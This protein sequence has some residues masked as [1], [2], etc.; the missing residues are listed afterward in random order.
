MLYKQIL[1]KL[2]DA[3]P[4]PTSDSI[5]DAYLIQTISKALEQVDA[6]KTEFN[7]EVPILGK[8]NSA[9]LDYRAALKKRLPENISSVEA[10]TQELVGYLDGMTIWGHPRCQKNVVTQPSIASLIGMILV[11]LYNP[12]LVLEDASQKVALAEVEAMAIV[13]GMIGYD[14]D[15][16]SGTFT[17]GGTG[18]MLYALKVGLEKAFGCFNEKGEPMAKVMQ[19]GVNEKIVIFTSQSSH[20]CV[21]S[22][23]GWLGLGTKNVVR[24]PINDNHEME[25]SELRKQA[26]EAVKSGRKIAFNVTVGTTDHFGLDDLEAV[27]RLRDDLVAKYKL[28]YHPHV[29][30]DAVIGWA[31]SVFNDYDFELNP[32]GFSDRT[33]HLLMRTGKRI[34]KLSKADSIGIDFHKTGFAP[35]I[36]SLVLFKDKK[37]LQWLV[38]DPR[39]IP[40]LELEKYE[41]HPGLYTLETSRSGTGVLGALANLKLFG[42]QG[43]QVLIGHLV[44]MAQLLGNKLGAHYA[45]TIVNKDNL[46]T[47]TLFRVYPDPYS[48]Q[49]PEIVKQELTDPELRSQLKRHNEYNVKLYEYL[50]NKAL[51]GRGV[52]ISKTQYRKTEYRDADGQRL[53][54]EQQEPVVALKSYILSPFVDEQSVEDLVQQVL[55]AQKHIR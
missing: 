46:G 15:N 3:F 24:I 18:T 38:R 50:N 9:L 19:D 39:E 23:V 55:E 22:V 5:R 36:S 47:V 40:Y 17:F 30:A 48:K 37:D 26:E 8:P 28:S 6:L 12:N 45:T 10:V 21:D 49:T 14:P 42:K 51:E 29:H 1:N 34:S 27:V 53:P 32:L 52:I 13:S 11:A 25:I 20:Y 7:D 16:A 54:D 35:Y 2:R 44:E 33:T 43:W 41:Y 31:W 4:Q